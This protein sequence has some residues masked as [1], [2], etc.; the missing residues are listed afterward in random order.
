MKL[1]K[2]KLNSKLKVL[3]LQS[4]NWMYLMIKAY[5][6]GDALFFL[7]EINVNFKGKGD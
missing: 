7:S 1:K 3:K 4:N 2:S 6:S 5:R